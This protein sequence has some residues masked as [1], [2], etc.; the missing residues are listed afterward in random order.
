[1][2][3]GIITF[4][5]AHN[6]GSMLQAYA[7]KTFLT[8]GQNTAEIINYRTENQKDI[9]AVFTKRKGFRFL[10]KNMFACTC[11]KAL[12]SKYNLF[13]NFLVNE[14]GCADEVHLASEVNS[15][16]FDI[17]VAGSDQ[18][19]NINT[20][21]FEW[22]YFL[23]GVYAKK[24]AYAVSCGPG[25]VEIT[26][27][28]RIA[29]NLAKFSDISVRDYST[30]YFVEQN[31]A[32][33]ATEVCDPVILLKKQEWKKLYQNVNIKKLPKKYIFFYTLSCDKRMIK[34][35]KRISKE[36]GMP[37]VISQITNQYDML[38]DAHRMLD[39]GPK[40]FLYLIDNASIVITSSY[41]AMLFS[42][43]FNKLFYV[44]AGT[45]DNRKKDILKKYNIEAQSVD[46]TID[47]DL[48][49]KQFYS[50]NI[51]FSNVVHDLRDK[52]IRFIGE[53]ILNGNM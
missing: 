7:L 2:R 35:V 38:L 8:C 50:E 5:A 24:C 23:E 25:N 28:Q 17:V 37:I 53:K 33:I 41:H 52:G 42:L 15:L 12:S 31:S 43:V 48:V 13:E 32:K 30:K 22:L 4:H 51:D 11:Y 27:K 20:N 19:W 34:I 9:Y 1:M 44:I 16:A 6:Y 14:L 46:E 3:I 49:K 10:L 18:I 45:K 36:M 21:D 29:N 26:D 47:V 40:E 39:C